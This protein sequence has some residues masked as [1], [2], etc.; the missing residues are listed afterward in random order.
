MPWADNVK[1][2]DQKSKA[3]PA[4]AHYQYPE[5]RLHMVHLGDES[6]QIWHSVFDG[7]RW[8]ANVRIEGQTSKATPALAYF[9]SRLHMV[10]LGNSSNDLWHSWWDGTR[11][12]ANVRIES[13][14]GFPQTSKAAP[15]LG[16][17]DSLLHMVHLGESSDQ[18]WWSYFNG[19][20][21]SRDVEVDQHFSSLSP[22][23]AVLGSRLHMVHVGSSS[24][25]I[26]HSQ[27]FS[28]GVGD[29]PGQWTEDVQVPDQF[30]K[31]SPAIA[32]YADRLRMV[33]LGGSSNDIW[34]SYFVP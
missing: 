1:V 13:P 26:W 28:N 6:N 27:F 15:A 4:V 9:N 14:G 2:E 32:A 21:W 29:R 33:H 5:G 8:L 3:A 7:A 24:N 17:F 19:T 30:S 11:W 12:S 18:I 25:Q 16:Y 20:G 23:L 10:H 31:A 34:Y 22:S